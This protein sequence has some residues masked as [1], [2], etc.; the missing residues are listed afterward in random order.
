MNKRNVEKY[1]PMALEEVKKKELK[2][3]IPKEIKGYISSYGASIIQSG[4]FST[5]AFYEKKEKV[6]VNDLIFEIFKKSDSFEVKENKL[7]EFVIKNNNFAV[8][9]EIKDIVIALKL[10]IRALNLEK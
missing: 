6:V 10:S 3:M 2:G 9:E 8:K 4:L 5:V 1:I 7:L